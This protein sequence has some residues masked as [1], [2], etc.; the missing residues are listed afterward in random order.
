MYM[1]TYVQ[2][3]GHWLGWAY[4][5]EFEG[6]NTFLQI[7]IAGCFFFLINVW[8]ISQIIMYQMNTTLFKDGLIYY[9]LQNNYI[10]NKE[11]NKIK[12]YKLN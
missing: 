9:H 7:W 3:Q 4:L 11:F 8:I 12:K 1:C 10:E 2:I 6:Y 5:L